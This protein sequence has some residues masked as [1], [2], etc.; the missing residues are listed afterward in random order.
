M[1][2]PERST[3]GCFLIVSFKLQRYLLNEY[4]KL[5]LSANLILTIKSY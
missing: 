1:E 5:K 3:H 4:Y 2:K